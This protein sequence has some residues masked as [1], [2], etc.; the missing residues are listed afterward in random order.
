MTAPFER[1]SAERRREVSRARAFHR[2]D[3][4]TTLCRGYGPA[5][6]AM[7]ALTRDTLSM[8]GSVVVG[9]RRFRERFHVSPKERRPSAADTVEWARR[10]SGHDARSCLERGTD[11]SMGS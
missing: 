8:G 7:E 2:I 9:D 3:V 10:H 5:M 4:E 6:A 11:E 1:T